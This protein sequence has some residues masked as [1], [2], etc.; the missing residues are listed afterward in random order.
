MAANAPT[1]I[2]DDLFAAAKAAGSVMSRSAAQQVTHW[3]RIGMQLEAS[4]SVSQRDIARVLAGQR[5]YD[6]LSV[7]EQAIVRAEWDERMTAAR[8]GLDLTAELAAAGESWIEADEQGRTVHRHPTGAAPTAAKNG[9]STKKATAAKKV[10]AP[11]VEKP[12]APA[13]ASGRRRSAH[14]EA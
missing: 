14:P 2:D 5:S 13:G 3:A 10:A 6:T 7:H 1:R 4:M 8:E 11:S 9:R 12:P